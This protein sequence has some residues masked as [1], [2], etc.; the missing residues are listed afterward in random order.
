[1]EASRGCHGGWQG[2]R[3]L[4]HFHHQINFG[5]DFDQGKIHC[6]PFKPLP[7]SAIEHL[8]LNQVLPLALSHLGRFVL[9]ASGVV[10]NQG[11][12]AFTGVSG[13]GKSTI[14]TSLCQKGYPLITDDCLTIEQG[15]NE[16]MV[17]PG[18]PGIRLWGNMSRNLFAKENFKKLDEYKANQKYAL[19]LGSKNLQYC[20]NKVHLKWI[21]VLDSN[22]EITCKKDTKIK[23]ETIAPQQG[24]IEFLKQ[25]FRLDK[26]SSDALAYE[27]N[28]LIRIAS[29]VRFRKITY[30]HNFSLLPKITAAILEHIEEGERANG[31]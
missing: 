6:Y 22:K 1:M 20:E 5:L 18:Y 31:S 23:I 29:S 9:H 17:I 15:E 26:R 3:Y 2:K 27:F 8:I 21:F 28:R 30:P 11:V 12:V 13:Q 25:S 14:S 19:N 16:F 24:V 7:H 10:V 4:L